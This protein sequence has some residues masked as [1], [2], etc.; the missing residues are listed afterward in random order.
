M[1]ES[2]AFAS[3]VG[4]GGTFLFTLLLLDERLSELSYV[5]LMGLVAIVSVTI[6]VLPRLRELNLRQLKLVVTEAKE[7]Q[8]DLEK[9]L[10]VYQGIEEHR[11][12]PM[13]LN[14]EKVEEL[15][16]R[17][18]RRVLGD[19]VMQYV[20]GCIRRER[21]RVAH[22]LRV[23]LNNPNLAEA[24]SDSRMD[25]NVFKWAGPG[26]DLIDPPKT[27]KEREEEKN[28]NS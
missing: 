12:D 22:V 18:G 28:T 7:L 8:R 10:E 15:G 25:D 6:L 2:I 19:A 16:L 14:T 13:I 23:C 20:A 5:S 9:V 17:S 1:K 4:V 26:S 24:V 11:T 21:Q 27:A 3:I